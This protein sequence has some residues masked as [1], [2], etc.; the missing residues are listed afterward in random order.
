LGKT[1]IQFTW[2]R[3]KPQEAEDKTKLEEEEQEKQEEEERVGRRSGFFFFR[4]GY[5]G[6]GYYYYY[7]VI[8]T[9]SSYHS[10]Y[11]GLGN[12]H[13]G[14]WHGLGGFAG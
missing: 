10:T 3:P 13:P 2:P 8:V 4:G 12:V 5:Y 7:P 9:H 6:G 11:H 1:P 14:H